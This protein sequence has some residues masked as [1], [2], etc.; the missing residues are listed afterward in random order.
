MWR[1]SRVDHL[2]PRAVCVFCNRPLRSQKGI[3]IVDGTL[4]AYAGPNCAKK[5]LGPPDERLLDVSRLALLVV[6]DDDSEN[7]LP[8]LPAG[9]ATPNPHLVPE[10]AVTH[11]NREPLPPIDREIE[12][13]RLRYEFMD[14]FSHHRSQLLSDAFDAY[15]QNGELDEVQRK[16]VAG[17]IRNAAEQNTI[18]SEVNVKRCIGINHWLQE[19][20]ERT[21]PDRRGF[22]EA[23]LRQLHRHWVLT[24]AQIAA[25]NKWG[26]RLR[27]EVHTFPHLDTE[28]FKGVRV[29]AFMQAK[30]TGNP[31]GF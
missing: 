3:V 18:F 26:A 30:K 12:Y 2:G 5:M 14:D 7:P 21:H 10:S 27:R 13:L 25:V 16:R 31:S 20:V 19:A 15:S 24:S 22:L 29:P 11:P 23:M 9:G 1:Y 6:S 17:T 8:L 28:V 4:E